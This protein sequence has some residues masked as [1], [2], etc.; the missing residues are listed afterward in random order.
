LFLF[1]FIL[2][3]FFAL[4]VTI[5]QRYE[6]KAN[7]DRLEPARNRGINEAQMISIIVIKPI[8]KKNKKNNKL[9]SSEILIGG[10]MRKSLKPLWGGT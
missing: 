2:F 5:Y 1:Y 9:R 6:L 8:K 3:H 7:H 4:P 10:M